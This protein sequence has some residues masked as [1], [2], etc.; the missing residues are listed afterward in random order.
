MLLLLSGLRALL[1]LAGLGLLLTAPAWP[2]PAKAPGRTRSFDLPSGPAS[3]A[4][5]QFIAQAGVQ[6]LYVAEEV[7]DV[8]TNAVKG[9]FTPR[10]AVTRLL[11]HTVLTAV[12][13]ENGAIAIN[14]TADPNG[15]RAA[16]KRASDRPANQILQ[17][18]QS[19]LHL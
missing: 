2:A 9:E 7:S 3:V 13:T 10:E 19:P 14:R 17:T 1:A 6:V 15:Q 12:E 5:K 11:A 18:L 16:H 4:L 8:R